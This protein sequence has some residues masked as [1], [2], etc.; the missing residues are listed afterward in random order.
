MVGSARPADDAVVL[1]A[2]A[3]PRLK[4]DNLGCGRFPALSLVPRVLKTAG[5]GV[6][7]ARHGEGVRP[8]QQCCGH[9]RQLPMSPQ[10]LS[11]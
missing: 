11:V 6:L 3:I 5:Y 9:F 4:S 7:P 1:A 2:Q 10:K 8:Q